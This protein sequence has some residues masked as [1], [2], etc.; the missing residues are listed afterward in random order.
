[1]KKVLI[2]TLVVLVGV[3]FFAYA[4]NY[5]WVKQGSQN[6]KIG[7]GS[8]VGAAST[9]CVAISSCDGQAY[10]DGNDACQIGTGS[11]STDNSLQYRSTQLIDGVGGIGIRTYGI[12]RLKY[13]FFEEDWVE[14]AY[15]PDEALANESDPAAKISEVADRGAWLLSVGDGDGDDD[16][17]V[18]V[19]D[20]S[21]GG[22]LKME[23]TDKAGDHLNMQLNGESFQIQS[24]KELWFNCRVAVEDVSEDD[25][26][27]GLATAD[28]DIIASLPNDCV[29]FMMDADGS[30]D[31]HCSQDGTDTTDD[32]DVDMEDGT[33]V[34][35]AFYWDGVDTIT[36]AVNGTTVATVTD[37][38]TTVVI[39]D[40]E[41]LSPIIAVETDD[42]GKDYLLCDY[43]GCWVER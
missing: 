10:V 39:P 43:V 7:F 42:T 17:V 2:P 14:G 9:G 27:V 34:T 40:D 1:M 11:N 8:V 28:T 32:T 15:C 20:D 31:Y 24:G 29:G 18:A 6:Q 16:E 12:M 30:I 21:P 26:F 36:F 3:A 41:A 25:M 19:Q 33:Y 23:T 38:G 37:N 13:I 4:Q 35:L 22:V 5:T